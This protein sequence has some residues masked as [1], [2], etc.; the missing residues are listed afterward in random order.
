M[1]TL[2]EVAQKIV[3]IQGNEI[4]VR[5][6]GSLTVLYWHLHECGVCRSL[7]DAATEN[8]HETCSICGALPGTL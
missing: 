5:R 1:N 6:D 3:E 7:R 8:S 2:C 4:C